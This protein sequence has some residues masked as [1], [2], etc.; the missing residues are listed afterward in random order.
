MVISARPARIGADSLQP[1]SSRMSSREKS[2]IVAAHP[3]DENLWF[4]SLLSGVDHILICFLGVESQP[5]WTRG[6]QLSLRD[7]PLEHMSCLELDEAEVFRGVDWDNPQVSEYGL[8]ITA[9]GFSDKRYKHN[10]RQLVARLQES[11]QGCTQVFTHNPWGE[12][13]HVEHVQVFRAVKSLQEQMGFSLWVPAYVSTRSLGL[14]SASLKGPVPEIQT[15]QTDVAL[16]R[17]LAE[18][19]KRNECWTWF[20]D[21][22]WPVSE[23]FIRIDTETQAQ[24]AEGGVAPF[25]LISL[26]QQPAPVA[27]GRLERLG[28]RLS[29]RIRRLRS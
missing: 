20:D 25:N 3:D 21:Y 10:Y 2:I 29:A 11:L 1:V 27:T 26:R 17:K 15:R 22:K 14:M 4:S 5:G 9:E 18:L 24:A 13:G 23:S 19:Y 12:Y 8:A 28:R 16:A 7:Y 6:R